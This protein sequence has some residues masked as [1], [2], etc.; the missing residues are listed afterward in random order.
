V[1]IFFFAFLPRFFS[2]DVQDPEVYLLFPDFSFAVLAFLVKAP[3][4]WFAGYTSL[5]I[6]SRPKVIKLINRLSGAALVSQISLC[7][8]MQ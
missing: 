6:R 2:A 4:G 7:Y 8:Q 3:I 5:W 1:T